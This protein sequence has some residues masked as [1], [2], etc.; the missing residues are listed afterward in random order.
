[1][2]VVSASPGRKIVQGRGKVGG[3]VKKRKTKPGVIGKTSNLTLS[4][5]I[6]GMFKDRS[7]GEGMGKVRGGH[8]KKKTEERQRRVNQ[9]T[10]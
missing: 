3:D 8:K 10:E 5:E 9:V 4:T 2:G 1:V 6:R 7:R